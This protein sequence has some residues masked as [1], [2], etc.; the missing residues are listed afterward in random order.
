MLERV[1]RGSAEFDSLLKSS[2]Y[3]Q[4]VVGSQEDALCRCIGVRVL[5]YVS[6]VRD[7]IR[8]YESLRSNAGFTP[9]L[10]TVKRRLAYSKLNVC[11]SF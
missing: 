9:K 8:G 1:I 6:S 11:R 10:L 5:I 2:L 4:E 3:P 7:P